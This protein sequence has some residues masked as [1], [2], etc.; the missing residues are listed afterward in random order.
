MQRVTRKVFSAPAQPA[1]LDPWDGVLVVDKP[2]GMTSHDVVAMIRRQFKIPKVGHGGTLDP[3]ATGLLLILLG[4]GTKLSD[5]LMAS[6]KVYEGEMLLGVTTD[7]Q[8]ADGAV[9]SERD[10]SGVTSEALSAALAKYTGDMMQTPP[11][12]SAVKV[13]GVPLYKMARK[14]KVVEREPRFVHVYE[15]RLISLEMPR[16]RFVV[17]C[18]KGTYVRTLCADVGEA[19]GCGAHLSAL[20]RTRSGMFSIEEALPLDTLLGL[21][22]GGLVEKVISV[23]KLRLRGLAPAPVSRRGEG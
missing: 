13:N 12:V 16:A 19:L 10:P 14:G 9:V 5:E 18:T 22:V 7:S 8:D 15:F 11:M 17:R 3:Q 21:T 4:R 1:E 2:S 23:R 6:D 20:R